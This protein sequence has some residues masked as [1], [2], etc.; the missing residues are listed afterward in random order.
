MNP[1][2]VFFK[3]VVQL[4]AMQMFSQ[5]AHHLCSKALFFQDHEALGGFYE[6][7]QGEYDRAA[8]K[9]VALYGGYD[10]KSLFSQAAAK[11]QS[12]PSDVKENKDFF[13][14]LLSMEKELCSMVDML[15]RQGGYGEGDKN[16]LADIATKSGDRLYLIKR[17]V[18]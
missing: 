6:A 16:L 14:Y 12:A 10:M 17:R 8:E 11:L 3:M 7:L 5:A 2:E 1:Q 18:M 15:V 4:R 13:T 9:Y